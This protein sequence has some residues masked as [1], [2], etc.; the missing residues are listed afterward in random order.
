MIS[1]DGYIEKEV[2][3]RI[4]SAVKM[5]GGMS[6]AVLQR[7]DLSKETKLK[8]MNA[9]MLPTLVYRSELWNLLKQQESR[10]QA[11]QIGVLQRIEGLSRVDRVRNMD[12]RFRLGQEG[13]LD[14]VRRK[15]K[16]LFSGMGVQITTEGKRLLGAAIGNNDFEKK[17]TK[18]IISPLVQQ[19]SRLAEVAQTQPQ[20][21][22]AA[23]THGLIGKWTFL[24][25]TSSSSI[26]KHLQSLEDAI[27]LRL[28][29]SL[30]GR[31]PLGN[32]ERSP[33]PTTKTGR[34]RPC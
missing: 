7:K 23:I 18:T 22:H 34:L 27:R 28:I 19:V 33:C 3:A 9:T 20:A 1:S 24:T 5:I 12:I 26:V 32:D 4:G 6:E 10:V 17:F 8:V 31:S 14:V 21:P 29:P 13:I 15:Q 30:T 2:E 25:R 16:R 11:T